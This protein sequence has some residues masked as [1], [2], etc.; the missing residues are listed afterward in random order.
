MKKLEIYIHIPFCIKKCDYCDFLSGPSDEKIR[1]QYVKALKN[2]IRFNKERM[3]EY[4]VDTVFFGGGTPSV[5]E[6]EQ[7]VSLMDALKENAVISENAEITIECNPGTV[8]GQKLL[9]YKKAGI[10]RIS[11]GLQSANNEELRAIGRIHTYEEFLESFRLARGAGFDNINVDIMSALPGQSVEDYRN[12]VDKIVKLNPEHISS[13]SLIIEEGTP[14]KKRVEE[15]IN[16]GNNILP[17][18]DDERE[19]YYLT[20][21]MLQEAGYERYEISNYAKEGKECRHNVGYWNRVEYLGFG[22]GSASLYKEERETNIA[23]I[24]KYIEKTGKLSDDFLISDIKE[25]KD[26]LSAEEQMEEFMF[27]GLRL[28]KGVSLEAF[29]EKFGMK[30]IRVYGE[31]V[32]KLRK[33]KL[34]EVNDNRLWLTEKGIDVS[35]YVMSE[36]ML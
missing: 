19:M 16:Q 17:N 30:Y 20:K 24:S 12:T 5:L 29:E 9:L 35:N 11:F 18:E 6:G 31:I 15:A 28:M 22:T 34:L 27:L 7:I 33:Q 26:K 1:E 14:M 32:E 3:E 25:Y 36:F 4:I 10:N 21:K 13:Y 2:E 8:T 23:D